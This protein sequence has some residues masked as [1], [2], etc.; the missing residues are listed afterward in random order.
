MITLV[1]VGE[2]RHIEGFSQKRVDWLTAKIVAEQVWNKPIVVDSDYLLVMDGQHRM[3]VARRLG[4]I[5]VPAMKY[6]YTE[7]EI[8]SLRDN[9]DVTTEA[10]IERALSGE[11]YP[12]K[13]VKHAFP[14]PIP[15]VSYSLD[16][17][18]TDEVVD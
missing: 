13:T 1:P 12:Y 7:V 11:I 9:H 2:L 3:E 8:W 15:S 4:L 14:Q 10:V 18:R 5:L 17:L 16:Q 6:R